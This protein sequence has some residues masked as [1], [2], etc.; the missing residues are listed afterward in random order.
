VIRAFALGLAVLVAADPW[1][2]LAQERVRVVTTS[3]DLKSL[4]EAVGGDR[5]EVES[6]AVPKQDPH[7]I[8]LKPGQ[9][10]RLRAA[11]LL[12]RIGLDHE[13]WLARALSAVKLPVL[14]VSKDVKLLQTATPRLRVER[15]AHVH[16]YG[17]TH[18]WLNPDN[19]RPVTAA[20]VAAL[21]E[22]GFADRQIFEANRS[23]FLSRLDGKIAEW[24]RALDPYRGTKV[25]VV[26]D[27]WAYLSLSVSGS[28]SSPQQ[29][30]IQG[31]RPHRRS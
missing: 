8:E 28:R 3:A 5:V 2:A 20:I 25:V 30:R 14:D 1:A 23:A 18:Y 16:A 26:H 21:V 9:L 4:V 6:L 24:E 11:A 12:V 15:T 13:P 19:A 7:S 22:L 17:N 29:S 31:S 27:S 10:A